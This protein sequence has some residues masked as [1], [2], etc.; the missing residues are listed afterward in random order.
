MLTAISYK[1]AT[2]YTDLFYGQFRLRYREF[3]DRQNYEVRSIDAMEFDQFDNL[4]SVYLV[5][6]ED[7]RTVLGCSRLAPIAYGCM[8]AELFPQM[9]DDRSIFQRP[10]IWEG[11]RFCV[12]HRLPAEQRRSVLRH[13]SL[14]YI[15]YGL[16]HGVDRIIGLMPTAILRTVFERNGIRLERLGAAQQIG[17]HSKIQAASIEINADQLASAE[18]RT[19]LR[20][21]LGLAAAPLRQTG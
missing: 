19:G 16:A 1:E 18:A 9:V 5:Y 4:A 13:I 21:V 17:D 10:R 15:A 20:D 2:K 7:G 12:D 14:G 11:T 6:S 3:V 8:L